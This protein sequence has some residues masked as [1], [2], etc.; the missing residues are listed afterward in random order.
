MRSIGTRTAFTIGVLLMLVVSACTNQATQSEAETA[1]CDSLAELDSS[2]QALADLDPA[3]ASIEDVQAAREDV[4]ASFD[5]VREE[6]TGIDDADD[7][8]LD[9]AWNEVAQAIDDFP[10]DEPIEDALATIQ[11]GID[12]VRD[13]HS[14]MA[15]G[16]GCEGSPSES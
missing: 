6:I 10:S 12:A 14:E 3:S 11:P 4:Q 8:A 16:L 7:A 5:Q 9:S 2:L 15:N 1:V 13:A